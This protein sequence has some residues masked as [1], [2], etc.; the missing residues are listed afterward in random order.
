MWWCIDNGSLPAPSFRKF[1]FVYLFEWMD[2]VLWALL[3]KLF[4]VVTPFVAAC[5]LWC[6]VEQSILLLSI[7]LYMK[8][9]VIYITGRL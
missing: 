4:N 5:R 3:S 2:I 7:V 6:E 8:F 1:I 9:Y